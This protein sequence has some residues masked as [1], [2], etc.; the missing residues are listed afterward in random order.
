MAAR[1]VLH[2]AD[3]LVAA[4]GF[5]DGNDDPEQVAVQLESIVCTAEQQAALTQKIT[6]RVKELRYLFG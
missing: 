4:A 6:C 3:L 1:E 5:G 2:Q